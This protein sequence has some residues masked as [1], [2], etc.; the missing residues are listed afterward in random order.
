MTSGILDFK[1]SEWQRTLLSVQS[2]IPNEHASILHYVAAHHLLLDSKHPKKEMI[3]QWYIELDDYVHQHQRLGYWRTKKGMA[4]LEQESLSSSQYP[5]SQ[6]LRSDTHWVQYVK[7]S[8][9]SLILHGW[10]QDD[11]RW[12][13]GT[14][15]TQPICLEDLCTGRGGLNDRDYL[16]VL[17][18]QALLHYPPSP[19]L[20]TTISPLIQISWTQFEDL[21]QWSHQLETDA[22]NL[23][24]VLQNLDQGLV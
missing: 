10:D 19:L 1:H 16:L 11:Y 14:T 15:S 7:E 2:S 23:L 21:L 8:D 12:T 22:N 13:L 18:H 20:K 3:A 17:L 5:S 24:Q 4:F 9:E 6:W